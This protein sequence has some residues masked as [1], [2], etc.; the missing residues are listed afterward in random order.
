MPSIYGHKYFLTLI[1]DY[2]RFTWIVMMRLKSEIRKHL[3]TFIS[4]IEN[5]FSTYLKCLRSNN[6]P[7]IVMNDIFNS[8]GILHQR[9]CVE[10]HQQNELVER[11]H[12]HM[13]SP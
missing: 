10:F 11:K 12:Q 6:G 13:L 4:F 8:K 1:D 9:S 2:I 7:K 3:C 5:R